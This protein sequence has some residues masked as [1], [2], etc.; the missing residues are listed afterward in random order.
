[1]GK[2]RLA[3][4][5]TLIA[6][7]ISAAYYL[8]GSSEVGQR[9][10]RIGDHVQL[11]PVRLDSPVSLESAIQRRRSV[12]E[13]AD[14]PPSLDEVSQLLW[15]AQG[16]THENGY[17]TAPSAGG[18]HPLEIYLLA[19]AVNG[20][21]P[22]IYKYLPSG[23]QLLEVSNQDQ[24]DDLYLAAL[25]QDPIRQAPIVIVFAAVY[26]RTQVKYG[27]RAPRYVHMEVGSA[28]QNVYLQ[29]TALDLGT[30]FIGAFLDDRVNAI[31]GLAEDEQAL[32][33]MPVGIRR[34]P[35]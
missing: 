34:A 35:Q 15:A 23:H 4:G 3:V 5:I 14:E 16:I 18:L 12:R 22:G 33:L 9:P 10:Q 29:A 2:W 20:L 8:I 13:Y 24:R 28:A 31:L 32:C 19:G 26:Q 25:K 1:M 7:I 27:D 6:T 30:V 11:P 21:R 17:R